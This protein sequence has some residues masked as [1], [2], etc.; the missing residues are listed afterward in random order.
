L[1]KEYGGFDMRIIKRYK[2]RRLYDTELKRYI[3]HAELKAIIGKPD[4]FKIVDSKSGQDITLAVLGRL[5]T[6]QLDNE[7]NV[8]SYKDK[9]V[10]IINNGGKRSVSILK[11][12]FLAS[13]GIFN[14]TKKRAEEI[15]DSLIKAGEI[16][17]SERKQ[18]VMELLDRAEDSTAKIKERVKKESG[19]VQKEVNKVLDKIKKTTEGFSPKKVMAELE[20]LNKKVDK[21]AKSIDNKK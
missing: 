16:S 9:L 6:E 17:K 8:K 21:L 13:V 18:A 4:T 2:N 19:G 7:K 3:T 5:L 20:K 1:Y 11:N 15:I 12:T 14:L 10:E